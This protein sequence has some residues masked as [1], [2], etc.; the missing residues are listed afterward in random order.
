VSLPAGAAIRPT[1]DKVKQAMFNALGPRVA[2]ASVLDLFCGSGNL[3]LEALSRGAA[4]CLFVDSNPVCIDSVRR[5]AGRLALA[6]GA[7]FLAA[8]AEACL[9]SLSARERRFDLVLMDPPYDAPAGLAALQSPALVAIVAPFPGSRVL[10]E[11]ESGRSIPSPGGLKL[12][13]SYHHGRT[14]FCL[15]SPA[16]SLEPHAD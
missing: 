12:L 5:D 10:W 16:S 1:A 9:R 14:D 13:R 15:F 7:E 8:G 4:S 11:Q 2:G 6:G 3:G